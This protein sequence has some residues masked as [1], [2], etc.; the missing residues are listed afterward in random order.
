MSSSEDEIVSLE[1]CFDSMGSVSVEPY[2]FE[3]LPSESPVVNT[4]GSRDD[5]SS[6]EVPEAL[7]S[8][9]EW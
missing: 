9:D 3:P 1:A 5:S 6:D 7:P 4:Q 2:Q 8:M